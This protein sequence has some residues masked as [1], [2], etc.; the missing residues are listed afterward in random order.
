MC[1]LNCYFIRCWCFSQRGKIIL[2]GVCRNSVVFII[3]KV[4]RVYSILARC[5]I[6]IAFTHLPACITTIFLAYFLH[7]KAE[8]SSIALI[9]YY[10][11]FISDR[12][13]MPV[14]F[15]RSARIIL[16]A[17][18]PTF[19]KATF[20]LSKQKDRA[21]RLVFVMNQIAQTASIEAPFLT[22]PA[23]VIETL[24]SLISGKFWLVQKW[25]VTHFSGNQR[26][27]AEG[28][29]SRF[30]S[31]LRFIFSLYFFCAPNE[32]LIAG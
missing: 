1:L 8:F 30:V 29:L 20:G 31:G 19:S 2:S 10:P 26:L 12:K 32:G 17:Y 22:F 6:L 11:T 25:Q 7:R 3:S 18:V 13:T 9:N 24:L 27:R 23:A 14:T 4:L 15:A 5:T 28:S 16:V 21:L